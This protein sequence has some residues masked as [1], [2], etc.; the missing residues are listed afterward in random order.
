MARCSS[1][2]D[3][4]WAVDCGGGISVRVLA[5]LLIRGLERVGRWVRAVFLGGDGC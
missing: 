5:S 3:S 1:R 4:R 2:A